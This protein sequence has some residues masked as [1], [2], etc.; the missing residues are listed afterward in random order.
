MSRINQNTNPDEIRRR[1]QA[2]G[3]M[4][5]IISVYNTLQKLGRDYHYAGHV[6][7]WAK[8]NTDQGFAEFYRGLYGESPKHFEEVPHCI[9]HQYRQYPANRRYPGTRD[10]PSGSNRQ[11]RPSEILF[12]D[13][14]LNGNY[15]EE[16]NN[17]GFTQ[18][19]IGKGDRRPPLWSSK[20]DVPDIIREHI[21]EDTTC[22]IAPW[23]YDVFVDFCLVG[24]NS[25][26]VERMQRDLMLILR[27]FH[28]R[29]QVG[30]SNLT[31]WFYKSI[32]GAPSPLSESIDT[33]Q[34]HARTLTW[35]L[36]QTEAYAFP[37]KVLEEI[38][39]E[40]HGETRY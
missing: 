23:Q 2:N 27:T 5:F 9:L 12:S 1:L 30:D 24:G 26:V 35:R 15:I 3:P 13:N 36:L 31:G 16:E 20:E 38:D 11:K 29:S 21:E 37:A 34:Y 8:A 22:Y 7:D 4:G 17:K 33:K 25:V 6:P 32:P 39:I 10:T 28:D 19:A 14:V 18:P 40:I